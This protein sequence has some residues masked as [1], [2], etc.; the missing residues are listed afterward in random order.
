MPTRTHDQNTYKHGSYNALCDVC[1]FKYK[2]SDLKKRWD[3]LYVC[4]DDYETR[5]PSD[6][7]KG[8][9][10]DQAIPWSRPD[11]LEVGGVDINGNPFPPADPYFITFTAVII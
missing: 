10:D 2:A 9:K 5:H 3:G 4:R 11:T 1:Q 7:Q 8:V 6:F